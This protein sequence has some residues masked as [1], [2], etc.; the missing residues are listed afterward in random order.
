MIATQ[1][2]L[3]TGAA[4]TAMKDTTTNPYLYSAIGFPVVM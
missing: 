1:Q 2:K 4:V 3:T